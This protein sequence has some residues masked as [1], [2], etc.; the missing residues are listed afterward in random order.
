MRRY[1]VAVAM[2]DAAVGTSDAYLVIPT[3]N[4]HIASLMD[5]YLAGSGESR[6]LCGMT[7]GDAAVAFAANRSFLAAP[8][9]DVLI[10]T[11][12]NDSG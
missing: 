10:F 7:G 5:S 11:H 3:V 8:R 4:Q 1:A 9:D 2:A 12:G 6:L